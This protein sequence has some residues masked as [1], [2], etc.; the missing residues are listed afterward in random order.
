LNQ[1]HPELLVNFLEYWEVH[2]EK[3]LHFSWITD[4]GLSDDNPH[5]S[6]KLRAGFRKC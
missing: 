6:L 4:F 5:G 2:E 1:S 3:V